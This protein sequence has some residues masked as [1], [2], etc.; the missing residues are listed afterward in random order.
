MMTGEYKIDQSA[1]E[2]HNLA[3]TIRMPVQEWRRF[4]RYM[5]DP[6]AARG[7][8]QEAGALTSIARRALAEFDKATSAVFEIGEY[9]IKEKSPKD[10][11]ASD[12]LS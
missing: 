1:L 10:T 11:G 7:M 2:E 4:L 8:P 9:F 12:V 6:E 3:I 5:A